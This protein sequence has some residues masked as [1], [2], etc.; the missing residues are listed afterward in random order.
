MILNLVSNAGCCF[1]G[2][3]MPK[4][5]IMYQMQATNSSGNIY[6]CHINA[7]TEKNKV[8]HWQVPVSLE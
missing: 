5:W 2:L 1:R 3:E 8:E 7:L 6:K 4:F